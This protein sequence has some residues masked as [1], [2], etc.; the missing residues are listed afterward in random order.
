MSK[1]AESVGRV[2]VSN[3]GGIDETEVTFE[4][5]ITVLSGRNASNRTSLLRAVMAALGSDRAELK[6]DAEEG[7]VE[8]E[9]GNSTY[10]RTLSRRNG[11][12]AMDGSPYLEDPADVELADLFAFLLQSNEARDAVSRGDDLREILMRP[13]DTA[14]IQ[15]EIRRTQRERERID[16]E[17]AEIDDASERLPS[18]EERRRELE[19][20]IESLETELESKRD[21]LA[22]TDAQV[23]V[24]VEDRGEIDSAMAELETARSSYNQTRQRLETERKSVESLETELDRLQ[25]ELAELP[26]AVDSDDIEDQIEHLR[27]RQDRLDRALTQIRSIVE[28]N[29]RLLEG[30]ARPLGSMLD[31]EGDETAAGLLPASDQETVCWT[32]GSEVE[33]SQIESTRGRIEDVRQHVVEERSAVETEIDD[34]TSELRERQRAKEQRD[35]LEGRIRQT[36]RE[37]EQRRE[38]IETLETERDDLADRIE[39]LEARVESLQAEGQSE[40]LDLNSEINELEFEVE[41]RA[42]ELA[43]IEGDIE[44]IESRLTERQALVEDRDATAERLS[45]LRGRIDRIEREAVERFNEHMAEILDV[46]EYGNVERIWIERK[47]VDDSTVFDLQIVR[48]DPAGTIYR[49]TVDHLSESEREVTGLVFG[50]AGYLVHD[51]HE[52]VPLMVLDSLEAIDSER[53]ADLLAYVEEY[54]ECIMVALLPEDA[55]AVDDD[56]G[57]IRDI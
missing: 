38:R 33:R 12:V 42:D 18:L 57:Y 52:V 43:D 22:E 37:L 2:R 14:A 9:Y 26:A 6:A 36:E 21:Q 19:A 15:D 35:Q 28:F 55:A 45:N 24:E 20:T 54:S 5:G 56:Y 27:E 47:D 10:E 53:L 1:V 48:S 39:E 34:L 8:L 31:G 30:G 44:R 25:E 3:V 13:V 51:V 40:L 29:E 49:D 11:T 50:L 16:E 17:L 7:F 23:E 41:R 32:C 46:L 4:A